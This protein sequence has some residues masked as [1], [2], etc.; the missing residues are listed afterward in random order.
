MKLCHKT[1]CPNSL[2]AAA[3][4][5]A[6][7]T[8]ALAAAQAPTGRTMLD[9][10]ANAYHD[11]QYFSKASDTGQ[12]ISASLH[13]SDITGDPVNN[14][15]G[16]KQDAQASG[17]V[18]A[19][20]IKLYSRSYAYAQNTFGYYSAAA[21]ASAQG[22]VTTPFKINSAGTA[23]APGAL[24]TLV[25]QLQV[26][27]DVQ[28]D[29]GFHGGPGF[30]NADGRA[31][32]YFWATGLNASGC[33]YY[34]DAGCL[35]ITRDHTG[36]HTNSNNALR[37]W[38]LHIPFNFD[39]W[40]SFNLQMWTSARSSVIAASGGGWLQHQSFSDFAHTLRWGGIAEVLDAN[41]QALS[42]WSIES[43]PGLDLRV[44]AVPEPPNALL[45]LAAALLVLVF[46]KRRV[47]A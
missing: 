29:P 27:G 21:T 40:S 45:W 16:S 25:A 42:G 7:L 20:A 17:S 23:S 10:S 47:P 24:G 30:P 19:T 32:M 43:L 31:F 18:D 44:A 2:L 37:T 38:T 34:V 13:A 4:M 33:T 26:S 36:T 3:L 12:V 5:A 8:P 14:L 1:L 39:N 28:V 6:L 41:G 22:S 35:D 15:Y 11:S 9:M 46:R